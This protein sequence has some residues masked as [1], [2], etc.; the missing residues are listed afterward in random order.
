MELWNRMW[1]WSIM[2]F[3]SHLYCIFLLSSPQSTWIRIWTRSRRTTWRLWFRWREIWSSAWTC[4]S[5]VSWWRPALIFWPRHLRSR[6]WRCDQVLKHGRIFWEIY[7]PYQE[8]PWIK[9]I[10][11]RSSFLVLVPRS[12]LYL[13]KPVSRV[14]FFRRIIIILHCNVVS[15]KRKRNIDNEIEKREKM[16]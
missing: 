14:L 16:Q 15:E 11:N 2:A 3:I 13:S 1:I 5:L 12:R 4:A 6:S 8:V 10:K 9:K 7:L